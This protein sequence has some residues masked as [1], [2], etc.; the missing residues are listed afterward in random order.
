MENI[1]HIPILLK[2]FKIKLSVNVIKFQILVACQK[3]LKTLTNSA[4]P[5]QTA[6]EE[7]V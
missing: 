6:S 2:G 7:A 5:D 1:W 3:A 4:D